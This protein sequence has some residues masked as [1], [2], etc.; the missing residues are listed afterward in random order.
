MARCLVLLLIAALPALARSQSLTFAES[1]DQDQVIGLKECQ[2]SVVDNITFNWTIASVS[3]ATFDLWVS[4]QADCPPAST[5]STAHSASLASGVAASASFP[6]SGTFSIQTLL[7]DVNIVNCDP[8][9]TVV[10]VCVFASG[11]TTSPVATLNVPL[12]FATPPAPQ[13][14]SVS[15]GDSALNVSWQSGVGTTDGGTGSVNSWKVYY[16]LHGTSPLT[17]SLTV[18]NASTNSARVGGLTNGVEYDVQ[19]T[20]VTV[21][22]NESPFSNTLSGTPVVVNDF[23][24]LYKS[25][26]GQEQGGCAAGAGSLL[27]LLVLF[28]IALRM[29]RR[30]S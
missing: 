17:S 19:V 5:T 3:A 29:R 18:T 12:D 10:Y 11:T 7:N 30:R 8:A 4:D 6:S 24:R 22:G 16:G 25:E 15:P 9:S 26:G 20:A 28:P 23:W 13:L 2:G 14:N 21:S 27:A 1:N